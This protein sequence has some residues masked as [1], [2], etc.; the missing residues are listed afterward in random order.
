MDKTN[1]SGERGSPCFNPLLPLTISPC[2]PLMLIAKC[3][4]EMH[5]M[6]H[7]IKRGG[8]LRAGMSSLIKY[9]WT[10]SKTLY[11]STFIIQLGDMFSIVTSTQI[12][13]KHHIEQRLCTFN[14]SSLPF[15]NNVGKN[16]LK[17]AAYELCNAFID[18]IGVRDWPKVLCL[19]RIND[20][21]QQDEL[22]LSIK[23]W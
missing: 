5:L 17:P 13:A 4:E 22:G 12:L 15:I 1:S 11:K 23:V 21:W 20:F 8:N 18:D 7:C 16:L 9:Q 14:K 3:T 10:E 2:F 19:F 6:T